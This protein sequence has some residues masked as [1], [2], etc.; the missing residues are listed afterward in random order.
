VA[1]RVSVAF[2][3]VDLLER[4]SQF[5]ENRCKVRGHDIF[6]DRLAVPKLKTLQPLTHRLASIVG[7]VK[8]PW[9]TRQAAFHSRPYRFWYGPAEILTSPNPYTP[10]H[11][12]L[13]LVYR[14]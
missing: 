6:P 7:P 1:V 3:A 9:Q 4:L 13:T 12:Y 14:Q 2:A 10:S 8:P 5:M 11:S